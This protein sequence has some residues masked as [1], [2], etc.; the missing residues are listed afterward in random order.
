MELT[1][2]AAAGRK[3]SAAIVPPSPGFKRG[4]EQLVRAVG[5]VV[6]K[7]DTRD[8]RAGNLP[9]GD[10]LGANEIAPGI[11]AKMRGIDSAKN[12]VPIG[13]VALGAQEQVA[14]LQQF[15]VGF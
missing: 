15:I 12:T 13:I 2:V 14:C 3:S 6:Q 11:G 4:K 5:V 9:V 8:E 7:F 10:G 1:S